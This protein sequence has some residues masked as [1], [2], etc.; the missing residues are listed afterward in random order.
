MA[1][2]LHFS[3][4]QTRCGDGHDEFHFECVELMA[5]RWLNNATSSI[6]NLW[7]SSHALYTIITKYNFCFHSKSLCTLAIQE[8]QFLPIISRWWSP[9][10]HLL[11]KIPLSTWVRVLSSTLIYLH[12]TGTFLVLTK[13]QL[14]VNMEPKAFRATCQWSFSYDHNYCQRKATVPPQIWDH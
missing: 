8:T 13:Y 14:Y 4:L 9:S 7:L 10:P 6:R 5:V 12:H 2:F 3:K 11:C 1:Q